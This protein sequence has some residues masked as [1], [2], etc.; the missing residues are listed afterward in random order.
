DPAGLPG[1]LVAALAGLPGGV[2][3]VHLDGVDLRVRGAVHGLLAG[4][5][6]PEAG[7]EPPEA[8]VAPAPA[9]ERAQ[10]AGPTAGQLLADADRAA[11]FGERGRL[12][13]LARRF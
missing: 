3:W 6:A 7:S 9:P 4:L 8:P 13:E 11:L 5:A 10:P 12:E 1:L 2:A